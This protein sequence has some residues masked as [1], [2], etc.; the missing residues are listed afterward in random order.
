MVWGMF[1]GGGAPIEVIVSVSPLS[2][3]AEN[4]GRLHACEDSRSAGSTGEAPKARE[5]IVDAVMMDEWR[6][7]PGPRGDR[8]GNRQKMD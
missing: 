4:V 7:L 3:E 1:E 8:Q 2:G 5:A 6:R